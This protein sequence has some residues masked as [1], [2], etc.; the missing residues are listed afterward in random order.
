MEITVLVIYLIVCALTSAPLSLGC[1][2]VMKYGINLYLD[3]YKN[4][5]DE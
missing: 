1:K 5:M 2:I 3:K 4:E